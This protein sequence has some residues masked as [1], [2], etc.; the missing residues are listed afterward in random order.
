MARLV[1]TSLMV[2]AL[3]ASSVFTAGI[4]MSIRGRNN[5]AEQQ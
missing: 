4:T 5:Y 3:F 2:V 1:V